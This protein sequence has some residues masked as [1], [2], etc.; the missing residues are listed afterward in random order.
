MRP[1]VGSDFCFSS[2]GV[3][4]FG[5]KEDIENASNTRNGRHDVERS[6]SFVRDRVNNQPNESELF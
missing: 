5:K 4:V 1:K 6:L 3:Y 2:S